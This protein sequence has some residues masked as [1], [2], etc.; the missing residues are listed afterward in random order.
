MSVSVTCLISVSVS[1]YVYSNVFL[2]T[3]QIPTTRPKSPKLGRNKEPAVNNNSEDKSCSSPHG[4]Q[5]Q[6][7]SIK[8]KVKGYKDVSS[9]KPIRKTQTKPQSQEKAITKTE[10]DSA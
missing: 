2:S 3:N 6:N 4:K 5:Q 7:D 1:V 8:A 9:K 10:N